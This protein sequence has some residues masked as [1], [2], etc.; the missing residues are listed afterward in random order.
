MEKEKIIKS[1]QQN[2]KSQSQT[3]L[4]SSSVSPSTDKPETPEFEPILHI[5]EPIKVS[6]STDKPETPEIEPIL[7]IKEPVKVFDISSTEEDFKPTINT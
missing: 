5:K 7:H 2:T 4:K 1:A 3:K 6:P